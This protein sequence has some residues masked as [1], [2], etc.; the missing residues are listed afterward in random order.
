MKAEDMITQARAELAMDDKEPM[1]VYLLYSIAFEPSNAIPTLATDGIKVLYNP[2]YLEQQGYVQTRS[3]ILHELGHII[4]DH[5]YRVGNRDKKKWNIAADYAVNPIIKDAGFPLGDL[6][7]SPQYLGMSVEE[8]YEELPDDP[9][10]DG[11][12]DLLAPSLDSEDQFK[13]DQII[14]EGVLVAM[15][16]SEGFGSIPGNLQQQLRDLLQPK[17][18]WVTILQNMVFDR[19]AVDYDYT[20]FNRRY[21]PDV[22]LPSLGGFGMAKLT[23]AIDVS[24]SVIRDAHA[25]IFQQ[26]ISEVE[27]I[28][29]ALNPE[30]TEIITFDSEIQ[31][32]ITLD[33]YEDIHD[34]SFTVGGGTDLFPIF[35]RYKT[36]AAPELL[37]VFT[38]HECTPIPEDMYYCDVIWVIANKTPYS[39][40]PLKGS[41][42]EVTV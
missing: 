39:T 24:F 14:R 27:N 20:K 35:R 11:F 19:V 8:I 30:E 6:I 34:I 41:I 29:T 36:Q 17:V 32:V 12:D 21:F 15:N 18:D 37:I 16:H 40:D 25:K 22:Y 23:V 10:E 13:K 28:R 4:L 26:F 31:D 7:Y 1:L 5:V 9:N 3:D 33:Q 42:L 2:D 38:D